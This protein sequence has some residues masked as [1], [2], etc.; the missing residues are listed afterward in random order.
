[1]NCCSEYPNLLQLAYNGKRCK[2][3]LL[4]HI[5]ALAIKGKTRNDV[6][7]DILP[8]SWLLS[9]LVSRRARN[10]MNQK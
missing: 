4:P 5:Y 10:I 6:I 3:T 7:R 9:K 2:V 8:E 1:M